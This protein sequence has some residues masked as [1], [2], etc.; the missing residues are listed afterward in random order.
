MLCKNCIPRQLVLLLTD[1]SEL[2]TSSHVLMDSENVLP[3]DK[4]RNRCQGNRPKW[5]L[6]PVLLIYI[7]VW[8]WRDIIAYGRRWKIW[9][10]ENG[11]WV[12]RFLIISY[13]YKPTAV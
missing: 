13:H 5:Y 2:L 8:F 3:P 10:G 11:L 4:L 7:P 9:E 1:E 12:K 6:N